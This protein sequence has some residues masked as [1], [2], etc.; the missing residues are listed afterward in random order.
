V[1]GPGARYK[2]FENNII[3][4]DREFAK[5][6]NSIRCS[7]MPELKKRK[8]NSETKTCHKRP[9]GNDVTQPTTKEHHSIDD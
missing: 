8:I 2:A 7:S 6:E 1:L 3:G 4:K 9:S 5:C